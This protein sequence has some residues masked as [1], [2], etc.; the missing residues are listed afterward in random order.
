MARVVEHELHV[1][2]LLGELGGALRN[3]ALEADDVVE[4]APGHEAAGHRFDDDEEGVNEDDPD[5]RFVVKDARG[6]EKVDDEVVKSRCR[7]GHEDDARV[8]EDAQEGDE[9]E[10]V[11]VH[12]DLHRTLSEVHEKPPHADRGEGED[13]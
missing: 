8:A 9:D 10:E 12:L 7:R 11:E 3:D 1:A 2:A 6:E 13:A 4:E 5:G